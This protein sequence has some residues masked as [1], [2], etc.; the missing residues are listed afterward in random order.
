MTR[1]REDERYAAGPYPNQGRT[2]DGLPA[3]IAADEPLVDADVVVWYTLG[4]FH[5]PRP[6]EW[7]VMAAHHAQVSLVPTGFLDRTPALGVPPSVPD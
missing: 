2:G 6:E 1:F 5:R 4:V 7:P 3:W